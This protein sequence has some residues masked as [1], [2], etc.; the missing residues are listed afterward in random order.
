MRWLD[1]ITDSVDISLKK[2]LEIVKDKA[3]LWGDKELDMTEWLNNNNFHPQKGDIPKATSL[4]PL[5]TLQAEILS[6]CFLDGKKQGVRSSLVAHW[7]EFWASTA[8][9]WVQSLV[10]EWRSR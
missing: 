10:R 5:F 8:E 3:S 4:G 7:L 2:F 9:A 1:S 6:S